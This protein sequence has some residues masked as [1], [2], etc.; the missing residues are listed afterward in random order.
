MYIP[1]HPPRELTPD[2]ARA[3][4]KAH[5]FWLLFGRIWMAVGGGIAGLSALAMV[6]LDPRW[7]IGVGVS[8]PFVILGFLLAQMA[9]RRS[10]RDRRLL[11]NGALVSGQVVAAAVDHRMRKNRQYAMRI[12]CRYVDTAAGREYDAVLGTWEQALVDSHPVGR[13]V[14]ML[15]DE[16]SGQ[17]VAPTLMQVEFA[18]S[19]PPEARVV[20]R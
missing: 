9:H 11:V 8:A 6:L 10:A 4:R 19:R 20:K 18:G 7:A 13:D 12:T 1:E 17:A 3:M 2:A 14:P 5:W 16:A 15:I